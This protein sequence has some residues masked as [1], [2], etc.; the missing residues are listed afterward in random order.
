MS[1]EFETIA[2]LFRPLAE[3]APE[4]F[5]LVDDAAAIPSRPG[6]DLIVTKDAVVEGVHF[7][8]ADPPDLVARKLLRVNLS[9]LAAK[10]AEPYAYFLSV[11]WP[12]HW[13][14]GARTRFAAGLAEDQQRYGV[15]LLGGDTVA[16][17]GPFTASLTVLGWTAA[18]RM[19][20]RAG[21]AAGDMLLV[22]G[23]IGDGVLGL[24]AAR[25]GLGQLAPTFRDALAAR[26]RL[27]EPRVALIPALR[28]HAA[29]A[30]DVSDGLLADA[31][32]V[33]TASGVGFE[34]DLEALPLSAGARAWLAIQGDPAAGLL[35][36]A[37]GG[38]DY[39]VVCAA[40]PDE[41]D[42]LVAAGFTVI[43]RMTAGPAQTVRFDGR[44]IAVGARGWRHS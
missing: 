32:H 1:D 3:G 35:H 29:A 34:I 17:P 28:A 43:G 21:A 26:Y 30:A 15:R 24:E 37:T 18:G 9:D 7:L 6:Q 10:G 19:V 39:E 16:T 5:G 44:P 12:P 41:A 14:E 36:L 31:G 42:K 11:A 23:T 27:P 8:P 38:D 2:R 4:A 33:A 13:D 22:S 25:G 40:R 20:R